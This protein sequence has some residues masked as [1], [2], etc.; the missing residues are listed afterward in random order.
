VLGCGTAE[1]PEA[2]TPEAEPVADPPAGIS[3]DFAHGHR[4]VDRG[5]G[6]AAP[7]DP[8]ASDAVPAGWVEVG[9]AEPRELGF[10]RTP[11]EARE[12]G[13]KIEHGRCRGDGPDVR[14]DASPGQP[15]RYRGAAP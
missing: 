13:R 11:G 9:P 12:P 7:I 14:P 2:E 3:R 10:P 8:E 4:Q 15:R 1:A 5:I 6:R